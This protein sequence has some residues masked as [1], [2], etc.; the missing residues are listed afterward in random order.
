MDQIMN[1]RN[2]FFLLHFLLIG[3]F[4][5]GQE[6][7]TISFQGQSFEIP[8]NNS[9]FQWENKREFNGGH[10]VWIQFYHS[11]DQTVQN[12]L[13]IQG[14]ELLN[15][16]KKATYL[17]FVPSYFD[18]SKLNNFGVRGCIYISNEQKIHQIIRNNEFD[19]WAISGGNRL[20]N[21]VLYSNV[22]IEKC[23]LDLSKL[24]ISI[25][26]SP[27]NSNTLMISVPVN[28][29][30]DL[31]SL[32]YIQWVEEISSP[33]VKDDN[34][35]RNLHRS[36]S[37][38]TQTGAGRNYTGD[39]IGVLV[40][41]DGIV[42]PH[43]D[44]EGRID[45]SNASNS[46][47]THGD[48][49][50]GI[51]AGAGNLDPLMRGMAAGASIYV[52]NYA[53]SFLDAATTGLINAG[54]VQIT[55]SSYSD[56][57][58]SG[59]T[60]GS[61]TIDQQMSTHPSLLH[62]FSGGNDGTS[63]CG[64][65]AGGNW[66]NITGGHKQGKNAIATAN[67]YFDGSLVTSS[68]RGPAYDGRIKPDIA[69]N[70]QNQ[71]STDENNTY[72]V[73]G[74]TSGA[75][76]GIAGI[77]AQLYEAYAD[78]NAGALPKA[79]LIKAALLNTANDAGNIG[80]DYKFGWG[81]VNGLRAAKLIEDNHFLSSTISNGGSNL[82]NIVIPAGAKQVRFMVY[83]SDPASAPGVSTCL[84]NDID[85][86]VTAPNSTVYFPWILD[87]TPNATSLDAPAT[88]GVD[89]LNNME[90]VLFNNPIAGTYTI[91]IT[92]FDIAFG[93][94]EYFVVYEILT[95][96]IT[97][98]Y[99]NMGESF[100]PGETESLHWDAINPSGSTLLEYS[101]NNGASWTTIT[102]VSAGITNYAWTVPNS[103][104]GTAKIRVTNN[105]NSDSNDETFSIANVVTGQQIIKV[106]PDSA[107]FVWNPVSNALS[108]DLYLLG[109]K[110]MEVVGSSTTTSISV[111][112]ANYAQPIWFAVVARNNTLGWK[113]RRTIAS[114][115]GGG[116]LN[117]SIPNDL[118]LSTIN[119]DASDFSSI[120]NGS[121]PAYVSVKITN[122]GL[123]SQSNFPISF[124]VNSNT[125]ITETYTGT[126][127]SGQQVNYTFT[128]PISGFTNGASTLTC[129]VTLAGDQF[130]GNNQQILSFSNQ[131][132]A[133]ATPFLETF[134]LG[135][136]PSM[137]TILNADGNMTWQLTSVTG[138][139]GTST[140]AMFMNHFSYTA[141]GQEDIFQTEIMN[142]S[143]STA[144]LSFDLAKANYSSSFADGLKVD[145]ST[146]CGLTF[147][148]I[149]DKSGALLETVA[150]QS[151]SWSPS[152]ANQWRNEIVDLAPFLSAG[153]AMFRF[154]AVNGYG[155]ST[156]IDNINI[157]SDLN[158]AENNF[159]DFTIYPNPASDILTISLSNNLQHDCAILV[160][161]ELGQL[162]GESKMVS[163]NHMTTVDLSD[164]ERGIY[165]ITL[166]KEG[167]STTKRFI[168]F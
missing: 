110:Y 47:P 67:V 143:S 46:G 60:S 58:N 34:R 152:A 106:C 115:Y 116:L 156:Y 18:K 95:N 155:N 139:A 32:P 68:S 59:Y 20:V 17:A 118:E 167:V 30:N 71:N 8:E 37:L 153:N 163:S 123:N 70:G 107:T 84:V 122:T 33:S 130:A 159:L 111:P 73:F 113:S 65:G 26:E 57:C 138:A 150:N 81:I 108:Y 22:S 52:T 101:N 39:G 9:S 19:A 61:Q 149:Y 3:L 42:G 90:Q 21:V 158:L 41:D 137:W 92:G 93:P 29:L 28:Q 154:T 105:G 55:N 165:F 140:S 94:Q 50:A 91:N 114:Y 23:L 141:T 53:S 10:Y 31:V 40:R 74:G 127:N 62:V 2:S 36:N 86:K 24:K 83:W 16:Y 157:N 49:V 14:I 164:V 103:I 148:N 54:T 27:K 12:E 136:F 77:S 131:S 147:Q 4:S 124:Q 82:H 78:A 135:G 142:I 89:H 112:I 6:N 134:D 160:T 48:G 128:T 104:T 117:C 145:I 76:P 119:N 75:A 45:N 85:L 15:Y 97:V 64:Y 11:P 166:I 88:N 120:C 144:G 125:A 168:K 102:T 79:A 80:P 109:V 35:G 151:N 56:G 162:L 69:A 63:N 13:K 72:Q 5:N 51:F 43:I 66:G 7:H 25:L 87:P 161:N 133:I 38:D 129:E 96:P 126:I 98:T 121:S 132:T 44:F 146:D 1:F 100:V 99:P